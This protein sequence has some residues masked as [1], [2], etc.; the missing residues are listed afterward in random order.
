MNGIKCVECGRFL[1]VKEM[2]DKTAAF[3]Y[4]PSSE[5]SDEKCEWTCARCTG[6]AK[7]ILNDQ[8]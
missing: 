1:S 5:F 7:E 2:T 3:H 8:R 4:T 6:L